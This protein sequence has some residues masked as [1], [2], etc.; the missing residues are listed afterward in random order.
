M[1]DRE[2]GLGGLGGWGGKGGWGLSCQNFHKKGVGSE[3]FHK[4]GGVGKIGDCSKKRGV[5]LTVTN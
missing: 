2:E 5:S 3:F 1:G 4:K